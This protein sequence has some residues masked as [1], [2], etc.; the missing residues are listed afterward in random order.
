MTPLVAV[1]DL[2]KHFAL[3]GG[4]GTVFAVN[5]V[6]FDIAR[7]ETLALVGESGSGKTTV[8]RCLLRLIEPTAGEITFDGAPVG[9]LT[10]RALRHFRPRMQLVFQEPGDSLDPR[11]RI[12]DSIAEPMLYAGEQDRVKRQA[13]VAEL[14]DFVKLN[15]KLASAFPHQLSGGEQQRVGIARAIATNPD[16]VVLD[17]PTSNLDISVRGEIIGL[18]R[19][20]Q[21]QFKI[22]YLFISHDLSAVQQISHRVAVMY[23]GRIV[24]LGASSEIFSRQVHP[25]GRAL[26]SSVL[27]PDP[28]RTRSALVLQGEIPSPINLPS[29]CALSSRCPL[30]QETCRESVPR[31][32]E[33][34][35]GRLVACFRAREILAS[36]NVERVTGGHLGP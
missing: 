17:E 12:G 32:E 8:G 28:R 31:L 25:Y 22:A 35:G 30:V 14:L 6:T 24:E 11:L 27:Y 3:S 4:K 36:G 34:V 7:G 20:L 13:R 19:R 5:G 15:P 21:E 33:S 16:L 10:Q 1:R 9:G 29:G 23:L 2:V 26:L 18:L